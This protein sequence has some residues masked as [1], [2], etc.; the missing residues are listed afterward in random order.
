MAH[1][2]EP[3]GA[4]NATRRHL[5]AALGK[6]SDGGACQQRQGNRGQ[7]PCDCRKL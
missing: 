1:N 6:K 7:R 2:I 4:D 5:V 3:D